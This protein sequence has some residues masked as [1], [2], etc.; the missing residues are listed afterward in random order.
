[1]SPAHEPDFFVLP[2]PPDLEDELPSSVAERFNAMCG[3]AEQIYKYA[4]ESGQ[5]IVIPDDAALKS[6]DI[7]SGVTPLP[8]TITTAEQ[9]HLTALLQ[10]YDV[11]VVQNAQQLRNFC[12][13][14]LIQ[15]AAQGSSDQVQ[16]RAVEMLGKVKDVALF[17]ERSTVL[18]EHMTTEQIQDKLREKINRMRAA[19]GS[20]VEVIPNEVKP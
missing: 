20:A 17:E 1:M 3:A 13:N 19:A 2:F 16:L 15:K 18:V 11:T 5:Q 6:R 4:T 12:T 7:F 8:K 9:L 10:A 14:I